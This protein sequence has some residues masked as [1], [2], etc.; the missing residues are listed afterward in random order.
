MKIVICFVPERM[1]FYDRV[2]SIK[3]STCMDDFVATWYK[4]Q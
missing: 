4:I 2:F 1:M 3:L